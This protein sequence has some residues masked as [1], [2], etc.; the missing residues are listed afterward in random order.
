MVWPN[1]RLPAGANLSFSHPPHDFVKHLVRKDVSRGSCGKEQ[2][3]TFEKTQSKWL[4]DKGSVRQPALMGPKCVRI[5]PAICLTL[6]TATQIPAAETAVDPSEIPLKDVRVIRSVSRP[7]RSVVHVDAVEARL[8]AGQWQAPQP[9]D[10]LSTPSGAEQRWETATAN[11]QGVLSASAARGGYVYWPVPSDREQVMLLEAAG[12]SCVYVNGVIRAGDSYG[13]GY[14]RL[15]VLLRQGTND[16]LF[17]LGRGDL[18][19]KLIAAPEPLSIHTAD[20]TLPDIIAGETE[21]LWG[22]AVLLNATTHFVRATLRALEEE[23]PETTVTIPPLGIHKTPFLLHPPLS[24]PTNTCTITLQAVDRSDSGHPPAR[25]SV[26]LRVRQPDQSHVRTFLSDIDGSVQYYAVNPAYLPPNPGTRPALFLSLHGAG[27]EARGQAEAYHPKS[28]GHIVCPT[29]RRPFGFDWEEWGRWDALEVLALAKTRYQPDP[30]RVYLTGHSMGGH[31]AWQLG[32]LFPDQFAAVGP[33]A[34]W[35][36][37]SSYV[38]RGGAPATNAVQQILRRAAAAGDTLLMAT[39]YLQEGVY[40]LHGDADD[41]VP[42]REARE[43]RR[44]LGEFHRD[45][46]F[47]EQPG[48]GHWWDASDEPGTDCVD[49]VPM[50]DF[51]AHHVIPPASSVRRVRFVTVNPAVSSRSHWVRILTQQRAL[52]PSAVDLHCDPGKRRVAGTTTNVSRLGIEFPSFKPGP[53]LTL[54]LDGQKLENV[55]LPEPSHGSAA[56][57]ADPGTGP[58]LFVAREAGGEWR[59]DE[60]PSCA[61]KHPG[62]SGPF[63]EAFRNH[64]VLVYATQGTPEENAWSLAKA[65]YDSETF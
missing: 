17:A 29:N 32:A 15:P 25:A 41:N 35:I 30:A 36:S 42:V 37:F 7:S 19:A 12:H 62:R 59:V 16:F 57:A 6:L 64:M 11:E 5:A 39:N 48:A 61:L 27:V 40:I 54:E 47:H 34:G 20:C 21:P 26:T 3:W 60:H 33:S 46:D 38:N 8:V 53:G 56:G 23:S 44:V 52:E 28:W 58:G 45:L 13:Y 1:Q 9:G 18:R 4:T 31:G 2:S 10:V 43:M 55:A 50:F 65:S 22:A 49:W 24:L 51:F 14:L 63:R